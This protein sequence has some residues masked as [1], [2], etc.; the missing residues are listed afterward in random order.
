MQ[1][2]ESELEY[3]LALIRETE[4]EA[5]KIARATRRAKGIIAAKLEQQCEEI[6]RRYEALVQRNGELQESLAVEW[7]DQ[8]VNNLLIFRETVALGLENPTFDDRRRWLEILQTRVFVTD[9]IAVNTC[10]LSGDPQCYNLFQIN[11]P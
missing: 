3:V 1:P 9:G 6:N 2:K 4:K 7:T 10:R 5:E 11:K 8:T